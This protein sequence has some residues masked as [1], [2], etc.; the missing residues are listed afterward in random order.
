MSEWLEVRPGVWE[1]PVS[2]G[3]QDAVA[4][5][6]RER[7]PGETW[8]IRVSCRGE[9][10]ARV[11][12]YPSAAHARYDVAEVVISACAPGVASVARV[13]ARM[14]ALRSA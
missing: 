4:R 7:A 2:V 11:G 12:G 1:M 5:V 9:V 3:G 14:K 10:L 6:E 8:S 13:R